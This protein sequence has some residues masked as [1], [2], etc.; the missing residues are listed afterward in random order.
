MCSRNPERR[1]APDPDQ[2]VLRVAGDGQHRPHVRA[3]READEVRRGSYPERPE[4]RQQ[5]GGDDETDRVIDEQ[6][7]QQAAAD[8]HA[9]QQPL[10]RLGA[11]ENPLGREL[12]ELPHLEVADDQ[13][14]AEQ[15]DQD[16]EID[17]RVR[18]HEG[19]HAKRDHRDRAEQ[20]GGG[21]VEMHEGQPLDG[22][23]HVCQGEDGEAGRQIS[24][25]ENST[26]RAGCGSG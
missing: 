19:Q 23:E 8:H 6:G 11:L 4:R 24:Q 16:V 5:H 21:P 1:A 20:A 18:V 22:D 25:F 10:G 2:H 17:G 13:H 7:R 26:P 3:H 12:E 9:E 15:E 14:Q